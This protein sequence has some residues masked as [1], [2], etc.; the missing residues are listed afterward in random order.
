MGVSKDVFVRGHT[1]DGA[2][3]LK[4]GAELEDLVT[5]ATPASGSELVDQS[6]LETYLDGILNVYRL[7][8]KDR[9]INGGTKLQLASVTSAEL[10]DSAIVP[11]AAKVYAASVTN[12]GAIA[13]TDEG[14]TKLPLDTA[15]RDAGGIVTL[16]ASFRITAPV[17][18]FYLFTWHVMAN[19]TVQER[20][21]HSYLRANG[22]TLVATGST[23]R[24][25]LNSFNSTGCELVWLP[26][27]QYVDLMVVRDAGGTITI[28]AQ[29]ALVNC[30]LFCRA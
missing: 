16:G 20:R 13:L 2:T 28:P 14:A 27:G 22:T 8:V 25:S 5:R 3:G 21:I 1:F 23:D 29:N 17:E 24:E 9:G 30:V 6:T 12:S 19:Q 11:A 26:A 4:T 10:A 15:V 18:G 7:R